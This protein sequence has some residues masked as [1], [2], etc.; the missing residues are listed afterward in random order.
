MLK[1]ARVTAPLEVSYCYRCKLGNLLSEN[2]SSLRMLVLVMV[3]LLVL[4]RVVGKVDILQCSSVDNYSILH[5]YLHPG[6]LII[7]AI[8]S[9]AFI[10]THP[11]DFMCQ[12][13]GILSEQSV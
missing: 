5:K 2:K 12:P 6:D 4:T 3:M 13:P 7:S 9:Q 10:T 11:K 8:V 1:R